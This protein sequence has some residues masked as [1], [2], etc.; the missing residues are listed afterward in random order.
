[1]LNVRVKVHPSGACCRGETA[2]TGFRM[3]WAETRG[4]HP[5]PSGTE[6]V[7]MKEKPQYGKTTAAEFNTKKRKTPPKQS[8]PDQLALHWS[9]SPYDQRV[10]RSVRVKK[11]LVKTRLYSSS[12]CFSGRSHLIKMLRQEVGNKSD[13]LLRHLRQH[14]E[15][16]IHSAT[17]LHL[18]LS[19]FTDSLCW[20]LVAQAHHTFSA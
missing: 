18:L 6:S 4:L 9:I 5:H 13:V 2:A 16:P 3:Y 20:V 15:I 19:N 7:W 10:L 12:R 17:P 11:R 8:S 14:G 1:M